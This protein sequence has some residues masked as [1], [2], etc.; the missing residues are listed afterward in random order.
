MTGITR[1][2]RLTNAFNITGVTQVILNMKDQEWRNIP[3]TCIMN[4]LSINIG[5]GDGRTFYRSDQFKNY[6]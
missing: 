2:Q 4:C 1:V 3:I 6:P 5:Q